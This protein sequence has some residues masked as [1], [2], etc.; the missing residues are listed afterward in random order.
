L[1]WE[2]TERVALF[3]SDR[4]AAALVEGTVRAGFAADGALFTV[5]LVLARL[6]ALFLPG[7]VA[8]FLADLAAS[9]S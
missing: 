3:C 7:L 9:G 6:L 4:A 2:P 8:A 5:L 1:L